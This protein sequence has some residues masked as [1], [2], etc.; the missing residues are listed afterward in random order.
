[1]SQ[2]GTQNVEVVQRGFEATLR[3]DWPTAIET[4][5]PGIEVHDFDVPDAGIFHGE[6][7]YFAWL[8]RWSE[9]W[10]SWRTED[11]EYRPVGDDQAIALF[12]MIAKG[13]G[14]GIEIERRDAIV[15]RLKDGK[16]VRLE[17][18][19]DQAEALRAVGV[20]E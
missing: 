5:A 16:I 4:L 19:N 9:S 7:G 14:S 2:E 6:E 15:Y 3:E 12:R 10:Q 18:F 11:V 1:M 8:R 20:E 13:R 17:Y